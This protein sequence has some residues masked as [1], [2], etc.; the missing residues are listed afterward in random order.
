[1]LTFAEYCRWVERALQPLAVL[2]PSGPLRLLGKREDGIPKEMA[3]CL[4]PVSL[5][6]P[7]L[8]DLLPY[9]LPSSSNCFRVKKKNCCLIEIVWLKQNW[10]LTVLLL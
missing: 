10:G 7:N 1:M 4:G 2:F 3:F 6:W 9:N 5:T 8:P